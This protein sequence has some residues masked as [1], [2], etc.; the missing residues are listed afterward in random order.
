MTFE[1][2]LGDLKKKIYHPVYF[3]QGEE[4]Y[5]IDQLSEYIEKNILNE[6]EKEFN[7]TIVYG[8]DLDI[9]TLVSFARRYP[10]MSNYQVV[11]VKL[12]RVIISK[13]LP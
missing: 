5:Y 2:I 7:Q 4:P 8:R 13:S 3:L 9:V 10:M 11:I 12:T 6:G 1:Q